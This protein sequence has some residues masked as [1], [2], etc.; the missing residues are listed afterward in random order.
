MPT[1]MARSIF[2]AMKGY[3]A[4]LQI[5]RKLQDLHENAEGVA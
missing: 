3:N 2:L 4:S 5:S 1:Q